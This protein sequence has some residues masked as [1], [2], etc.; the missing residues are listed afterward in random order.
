MFEASGVSHLSPLV[1]DEIHQA[2]VNLNLAV[3]F[4]IKLLGAYE[5]LNLSFQQQ[6]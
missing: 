5:I 2:T 3:H 6:S 1:V 4:V